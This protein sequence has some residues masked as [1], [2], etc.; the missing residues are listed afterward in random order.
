MSYPVGT[1]R[2]N[3]SRKSSAA[4]ATRFLLVKVGADEDHIAA[5]GLAEVPIGVCTDEATATEEIVNVNLLGSAPSTVK[6]VASG[7][8]TAGVRVF[9][10]AAGKVSILPATTNGTYYRVGTALTT[11][12]DGEEVEIDPCSAAPETVTGN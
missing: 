3:I 5:C 8:I 6:G 1:H 7:A 4:I 9:A 10:A 2:G 12:A 11:A